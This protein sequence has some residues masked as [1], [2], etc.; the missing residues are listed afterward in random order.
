M[1]VMEYLG[2]DVQ[3]VWVVDPETRTVTVHL[4]DHS[5]RT[6]QSDDILTAPGVLDTFSATVSTLFEGI[7]PGHSSQ[8]RQTRKITTQW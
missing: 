8:P 7:P 3:V 2:A 6:L 5:A 1:K 4:P